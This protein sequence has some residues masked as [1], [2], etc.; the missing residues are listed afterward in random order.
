MREIAR[1]LGVAHLL[2]GPCS[3]RAIAFASTPNF[4]NARTEAHE[5]AQQYD[6]DVSDLFAIQSEI[7]R[8]IVAQLQARISPNEMNAITQQPTTDLV[9]YD[10]YLRANALMDEIATSTDWEGDNR[11]AIDL[12][13]RAVTHDPKFAAAYAQLCDFHLNLY[14]WV[15]HTPQRLAQAE[16]A[17]QEAIRLAP[18]SAATYLAQADFVARQRK[19]S[20]SLEFLQRAQ[21]L[22]PGNAKL[23]IGIALAEDHLG[24][25]REAVR[26][27]EKARELA[28]RDPNIPNQLDWMYT[29]VRDYRK[30][31]EVADAAIANFP[32]GPNYYRAQKVLN[33]L[34]RG[35]WKEA[36][37]RLALIPEKF[38]PSG[39]K[40][41]LRLEIPFFER[42]S[43]EFERIL[44]SVPRNNL[45]GIM[46]RD[47]V[48][49]W[50]GR[51]Q[52][53]GGGNYI[54][55]FLFPSR[56]AGGNSARKAPRRGL[57]FFPCRSRTWPSFIVTWAR[58]KMRSEKANK[59]SSWCQEPKM[60]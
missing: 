15:E 21:K 36:A 23:L 12:L 32:N 34:H 17:M 43:A 52:K 4:I 7:A 8:S 5:W 3:A 9:A 18:S 51:E 16:T 31:D 47:V 20:Q 11:R 27:L 46:E 58:W 29:G 24:Q 55:F 49:T 39:F 48:L 38:D 2:T 57:F 50:V 19:W 10:L 1:E 59:R 28:P 54:F 6:R 37:R 33:A 60:Q 45:I 41:L 30:S 56:A 44:A 53:G 42:D 22:Q 35:D 14:D 25:S 26:D 13:D 40:S